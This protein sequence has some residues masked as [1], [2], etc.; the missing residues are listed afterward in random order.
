M[1]LY[2]SPPTRSTRGL[3]MLEETGIPYEREF[4]DI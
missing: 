1:K 4:V 3:W 2:W